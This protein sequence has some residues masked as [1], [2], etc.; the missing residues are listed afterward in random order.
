MQT[1]IIRLTA[2]EFVQDAASTASGSAEVRP[3]GGIDPAITL[4]DAGAREHVI[5][6]LVDSIMKRYKR[7]LDKLGRE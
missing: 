1:M 6:E 4:I 2:N 5:D 3:D 7:A